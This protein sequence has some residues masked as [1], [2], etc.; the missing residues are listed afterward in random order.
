MFYF[1]LDS[2]GNLVNYFN[3]AV[4]VSI[5]GSTNGYTHDLYLGNCTTLADCGTLLTGGNGRV[6]IVDG[7]AR[8]Q[9]LQ[10]RTADTA[11]VLQYIGYDTTNRVF[12][13]TTSFPFDVSVGPAYMMAFNISVGRATGGLPFAPNPVVAIVDRGNNILGNMS[14]CNVSVSIV[15]APVGMRIEPS[16]G[17]TATVHQGLAS[18]SG[19]YIQLAGGPIQLRFT[20]NCVS[21]F[22]RAG[23]CT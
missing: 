12:A 1:Y 13:A 20:S 14:S 16:N 22:C 21:F 6:P 4:E 19:L 15:L 17:T 3:G 23:S 8:F 2:Q 7:V 10:I 9:N 11:Y 18:F 5:Q